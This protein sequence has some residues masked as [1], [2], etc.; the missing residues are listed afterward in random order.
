M[1]RTKKTFR[2]PNGDGTVYNLGGKRRKPWIAK[3]PVCTEYAPELKREY[4]QVYKT[5]G[6]YETKDEAQIALIAYRRSPETYN[7]KLMVDEITFKEVY[8]EWI[9]IKERN[10]S[11]KTIK[12][13]EFGF[14]KCRKI[15]DAKINTLRTIH[16]QNIIDTCGLSSSS[17]IKI[18]SLM[19][20]VCKHAEMTDIIQKNYAKFV[21][22]DAKKTST[23][24]KPFSNDEIKMLWDNISIPFVDTILIMIYSGYRINE[25]LEMACDDNINLEEKVFV[26]GFK[27]DAGKD[28]LVP[29]HS[30]IFPLVKNRFKSGDY[31]ILNKRDGN[32][33]KYQ[34]YRSNYFDKIMVKLKMDHLPHDCRH[35]FAT[36]L[37]NAEANKTSIVKLIGHK[38]F[39]ITEKVYTHKDISELRKA[40][41]CL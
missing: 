31:F 18:K 40:I 34:N 2:R 24:H 14:V 22:T 33:M 1:P 39:D 7:Q 28:R 15:K 4:R 37:N 26:G 30:K 9:K 6:Y 16:F 36:L 38:S 12:G 17:M 19:V 29:I 3:Y 27:T 41:D 21:I 10:K 32:R 13:Y 11:P 25:L 35:T 23:L 8:D 20:D 5:I